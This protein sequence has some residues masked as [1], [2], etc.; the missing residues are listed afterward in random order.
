MTSSDDSFTLDDS[1][2]SKSYIPADSSLYDKAID[3]F[4]IDDHP[5]AFDGDDDPDATLLGDNGEKDL[6]NRHRARR[7]LHSDQYDLEI[8]DD[9]AG[10]SAIIQIHHI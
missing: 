2:F 1:S 10:E 5:D 4:Q 6:L 9:D 3:L 8:R 7:P